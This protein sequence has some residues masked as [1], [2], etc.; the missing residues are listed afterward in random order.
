MSFQFDWSIPQYEIQKL[1]KGKKYK[2][3]EI[4]AIRSVNQNNYYWGVCIPIIQEWMGE[5]KDFVHECLKSLFLDKVIRKNPLDKR[6][7]I[8][9]QES[10]TNLDTKEFKDF[11]DR[12]REKFA[13][14]RIPTPESNTWI[15]AY[16]YY[17][18]L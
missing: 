4:K 15:D 7:K 5:D 12:I 17:H 9:L 14:L 1:V 3:V 18:N 10:T 2:I 8:I 11:T 13:D 16:N 6:R